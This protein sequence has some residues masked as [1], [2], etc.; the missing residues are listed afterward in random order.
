M[1]W[2]DF[3]PITPT[4]WLGFVVACLASGFV[5]GLLL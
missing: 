4:Q 2:K 1:T 5:G 3:L